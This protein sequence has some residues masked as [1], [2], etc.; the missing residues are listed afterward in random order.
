MNQIQIIIA[1]VVVIPVFVWRLLISPTSKFKIYATAAGPVDHIFQ[2]PGKAGI[3]VSKARSELYLMDCYPLLA[4][5][6]GRG[7]MK[8]YRFQEVRDWSINDVKAGRVFAVGFAALSAMGENARASAAAAA[9]S[10]LFVT[11][12]DIERP[13]WHIWMKREQQKKWFEIL[14]QFVNRG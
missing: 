13:E 3:A 8:T 14:T 1:C 4:L 9:D 7:V 2:N 10:G 5:L 11:V 12:R 6:I